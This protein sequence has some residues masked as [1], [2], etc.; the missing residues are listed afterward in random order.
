[1]SGGTITGYASDAVNGNVVKDSSG[2][3]VSD[4]GHAVCVN[5]SP[6]KRRETTAGATSNGNL[7]STK[8]GTAG[9][10]VN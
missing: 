5:S 4:R 2:T 8:T 9:G 7:D 3:V 10:W 1:V 6:V